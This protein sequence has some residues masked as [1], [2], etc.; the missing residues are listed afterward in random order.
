[1]FIEISVCGLGL[2]NVPKKHI[3]LHCA[4]VWGVAN[5]TQEEMKCSA[6]GFLHGEMQEGLWDY[7]CRVRFKG[8]QILAQ[9]KIVL[10]C[11]IIVTFFINICGWVCVSSYVHVRSGWKVIKHFCWFCRF[12]G[13][14][15]QVALLLLSFI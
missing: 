1:M 2:P 7:A 13:N 8:Y 4:P 12:I 5:S 10:Y 3:K 15:N 9:Y 11:D 6:R 14:E